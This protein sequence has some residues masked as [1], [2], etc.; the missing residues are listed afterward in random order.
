MKYVCF[1]SVNDADGVGCQRQRT[2]LN[3]QRNNWALWKGKSNLPYNTIKWQ[4]TPYAL[5][6][7]VKCDAKKN[8]NTD[9]IKNSNSVTVYRLWGFIV[10]DLQ[11]FCRRRFGWIRRAYEWAW[12]TNRR[13]DG[14]TG[15]QTTD[16]YYVNA[17]FL[18]NFRRF[19]AGP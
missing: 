5:R 16:L 15:R 4:F 7:T 1:G 3:F 19:D 10:I 2:R 17:D 9:S 6:I 18:V 11:C 14:Q 13:T 12:Q 8:R